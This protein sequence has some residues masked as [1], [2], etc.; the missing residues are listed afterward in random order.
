MAVVEHGS[1]HYAFVR[2]GK[3]LQVLVVGGD[4]SECPLLVETF[5][6]RFGNGTADL[7]FGTS[8]E[9][10]YQDEAAFVAVLHHDFHVGQVGRIGTEVVLDALFVTDIDEDTAE[11]PGKAPIVLRNQHPALEHVLQESDSLQ[12]HRFTTGIGTGDNQ[13]TLLRIQLHI[14]WNHFLVVLRQ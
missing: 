2:F 10:V 4:D 14:Q 9:F 1:I 6:Y 3:M 5:Q 12:A 11:D 13:D 8:T 7:W